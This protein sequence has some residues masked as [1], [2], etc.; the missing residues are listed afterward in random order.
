M[1]AM[2]SIGACRSVVPSGETIPVS[3]TM[4]E[5]SHRGEHL[6]KYIMSGRRACWYLV[7]ISQH[8]AA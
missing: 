8:N 5:V 1:P 6:E 4:I 3:Q 2:R 7:R